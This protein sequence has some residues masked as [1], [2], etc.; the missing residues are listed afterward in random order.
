MK[1]YRKEEAAFFD[2]IQ[3]DLSQKGILGFVDDGIVDTLY[4]QCRRAPSL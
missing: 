2:A 3:K 4:F 1:D